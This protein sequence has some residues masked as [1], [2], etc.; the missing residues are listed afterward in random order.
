MRIAS[1][2]SAG[3]DCQMFPGK[4]TREEAAKA[5]PRAVFAR[6]DDCKLRKQASF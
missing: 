5:L 2:R 6:R 3:V 1:I 4:G